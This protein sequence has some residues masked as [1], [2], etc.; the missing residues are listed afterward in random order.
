MGIFGYSNFNQNVGCTVMLKD[1]CHVQDLCFN[2]FSTHATGQAGYFNCYIAM[3]DKKLIKGSLFVE[4]VCACYDMYITHVNMTCKASL[5][6]LNI[7]RRLH[8]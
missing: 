2:L 4:R 7:F 6:R 1:V 3:K 5:M 8:V